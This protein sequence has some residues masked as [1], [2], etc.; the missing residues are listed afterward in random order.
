MKK[1]LM[2][3]II[4]FLAFGFFYIKSIS[5]REKAPQFPG[6]PVLIELP[7]I[8]KI[9][10][11]VN[12]GESLFDIFKRQ[13]IS[14]QYLPEI[15]KA[16]KKVYNLVKLKPLRSYV[17]TTIK[18]PGSEREE[19]STFKYS[20]NDW[21]YLKIINTNDSFLALKVPV[22]YEKRYALISGTIEN[23]L[24]YA[25]GSSREHQRLAIELAEIFESEIDFVTELRQGDRFQILVEELW[26]DNIFKGYGKILAAEFINNGKRYEAFL[27]KIDG[28]EYYFDSKGNSL[29][30][31][32]LRAPLRFKYISSGFS[33][34]RKHPILKRYRP[35]LGVDYA[36]PTGTPVSAAGTG[37]VVYAGW[38]GAY[39]KCVII[40]HPN[41]YKTY[42]GHL[43]RI[44]KGIKKGVKVK[45][46]EIIGYVGSTGLATGP[47]L[48]YR[49][50]K[51][52]R[53]I[54]P[55]RMKVP[56]DRPV[57][58]KYLADFRAR[59]NK[60]QELIAKLS[61]SDQAV[62]SVSVSE[63]R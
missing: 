19:L 48:D 17:I 7:E 9:V 63:E 60:F 26:K 55:L 10:G 52:G 11:I 43:S 34:R 12:Q 28:K 54:N 1:I 44:K 61:N 29:R 30:K 58:K 22:E 5:G 2:A 18:E 15:T 37:T 33:Y 57:P 35:H 59:V 31:A 41:G 51:N 45:Q 6:H 62:A 8:K 40:R 27:Y 36:A 23:N 47:H 38:K 25:L 49:V 46:G 56:R 50:K 42:Y 4:I 53:F 20:I 13:G 16:S 3:I 39:G 21:E 14:L 32:L 24:I